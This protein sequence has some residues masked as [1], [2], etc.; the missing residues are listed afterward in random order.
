MGR[1]LRV[2]L[3]IQIRKEK[4]RE[5]EIWT[6]VVALSSTFA[7]RS[8]FLEQVRLWRCWDVGLERPAMR[9]EEVPQAAGRGG[10]AEAIAIASDLGFLVD[11]VQVRFE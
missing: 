8:L 11:P 5:L 4:G 1:A 10:M 9:G 3:R 7:L 6:L 2:I